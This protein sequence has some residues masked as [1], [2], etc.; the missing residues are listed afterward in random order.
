MHSA[1]E[2]DLKWSLWSADIET[3]HERAPYVAG[4]L[5]VMS[6]HQGIT[7]HTAPRKE[8]RFGTVTVSRTS[9]LAWEAYGCFRAEWDDV[10]SLMDTLNVPDQDRSM[11]EEACPYSDGE[12]GVGIEFDVKARSL[13]SLLRKVDAEEARLLDEENTAWAEFEKEWRHEA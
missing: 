10:S 1:V 8:I 9:G 7:I 4:L 5:E 11:F 3:F 12:P 2:I 6:P 13:R